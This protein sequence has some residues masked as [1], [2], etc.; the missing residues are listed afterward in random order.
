VGTIDFSGPPSAQPEIGFNADLLRSELTIQ[1]GP[2]R[3]NSAVCTPAAIFRGSDEKYRCLKAQRYGRVV[4]AGK[5][6]SQ[7]RRDEADALKSS[8]A[9]SAEV[10][11]A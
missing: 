1:R 9:I 7:V 3:V 2:E 10:G 11:S 8:S 5:G 4:P 6:F